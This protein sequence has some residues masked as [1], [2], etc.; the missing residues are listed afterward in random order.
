MASSNERST[1]R[2]EYFSDAL[3]AIAATL[4]AVE[5]PRPRARDLDGTTLLQ[6]I[7]N[8]WPPY[9]AFLASFLFIGI[10]W[11]NHHEMFLR[12]QRTNHNLLMLS[13][14]FLLGIVLFPF[15]TSL[16][17]EHFGGAE[18]R[19]AALIYY[20]ILTW[21]AFFYNAIWWYALSGRRLVSPEHGAAHLRA[22]TIEYSLAPI[23]HA[24]AFVT[25]LWS[26]RLSLIPLVL[27]YVFFAMPRLSAGLHTKRDREREEREAK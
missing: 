8:N 18:E 20:G 7:L 10:A 11:A 14:L 6:A 3:I 23:L 22:L 16:L 12:I 2:L 15:G 5:L 13:L 17:M 27:L 19:H 24:A 21:T 4:L 25:A 9:V 26:V 1:D